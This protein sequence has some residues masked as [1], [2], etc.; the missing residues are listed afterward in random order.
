MSHVAPS[1]GRSA[2]RHD[3]GVR[4]AGG[5]VA[6]WIHRALTDTGLVSAGGGFTERS[7]SERAGVSAGVVDA[8]VFR[9]CATTAGTCRGA[10]R[11]GDRSRVPCA[12]RR[13]R[14][15]GG[16]D[17]RVGHRCGRRGGAPAGRRADSLRTT[18]RLP[19]TR[20]R[21]V[22]IERRAA[23]GARAWRFE[24][25][26]DAGAEA[27]RHETTAK[28]QHAPLFIAS[29]CRAWSNAH[30]CLERS[31][32][33]ISGSGR[34]TPLRLTRPEMWQCGPKRSRSA[35]LFEP[36]AHCDAGFANLGAAIHEH[37]ERL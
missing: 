37:R 8:R 28:P 6:V 4:T 20:R 34:Q 14:R 12:V 10:R 1:H 15:C 2:A 33:S 31:R 30:G 17:R 21:R 18:R 11:I 5:C 16:H 13:L 27:A 22:R 19:R 32:L 24:I 25:R 9:R 36:G 26:T 3:G 35:V 23:R 29:S 7:A